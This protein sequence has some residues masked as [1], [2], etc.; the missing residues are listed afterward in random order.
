[1]NLDK[2]AK[3]QNA[4]NVN[5]QREKEYISNYMYYLMINDTIS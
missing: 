1:M 2:N 5:Q 4:G 3:Q